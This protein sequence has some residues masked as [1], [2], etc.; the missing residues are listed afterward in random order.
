MFVIH[1]KLSQ[2]EEIKPPP[3]AIEIEILL[4]V[5]NR[6]ETWSR[7][8]ELQTKYYNFLKDKNFIRG[9]ESRPD[10]FARENFESLDMSFVDPTMDINQIQDI[11]ERQEPF[12]II[13]DR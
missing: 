6:N 3:I 13:L 7:N 1:V 4:W 11:S 10:K 12:Q 9:N 8:T 5:E 2:P